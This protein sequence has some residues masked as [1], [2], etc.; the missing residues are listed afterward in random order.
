MLFIDYSSTFNIIIP[1]RLI[2]KFGNLHISISL[3]SWILT[4]SW[5]I[6]VTFFS[7]Y[8][9]KTCALSVWGLG[10]WQSLAYTD[11]KIIWLEIQRNPNFNIPTNKLLLPMFIHGHYPQSFGTFFFVYS[12]LMQ[13]QQYSNFLLSDFP[14]VHL[15]ITEFKNRK[16]EDVDGF[17]R[18]VAL[19]YLKNNYTSFR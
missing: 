5:A 2:T 8:L 18:T 10:S 7:S 19:W 16:D 11:K 4:C 15:T 1:S 17:K 13:E 12:D 3:C 14:Q 9:G 6:A